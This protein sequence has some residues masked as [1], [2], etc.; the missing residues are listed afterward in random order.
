MDLVPGRPLA[1]LLAEGGALPPDV[2]RSLAVDLA[3][4]LGALHRRGLVHRDLK[5]EKIV[6]DPDGVAHLIDFGLAARHAGAGEGPAVG[7]LAY[8]S[9]EQAGTLR[10]A[11]DGRSDLYA[12]GVVLFACLAGRLPFSTDDVSELL[13]R[14]AL[15]PAPDLR[16]AA[17]GTPDDLAAVV[18]RLLAKDPDDRYPT[19]SALRDD[20]VPDRP[21]LR[22]R[23][24]A[25]DVDL[26]LVG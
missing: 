26:A 21:S 3:G 1:D 2:V 13:R 16:E 20:L 15:I 10:R 23:D 12:L 25:D 22:S 18:A 7:T 8:A 9:P 19:A 17:P 24:P 4:V 5:P 11:V 14:H 6:V